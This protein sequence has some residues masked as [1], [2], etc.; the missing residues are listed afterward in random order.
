MS[1]IRIT[2]ANTDTSTLVLHP[3]RSFSSSSDGAVT[4]SI[5]VIAQSSPFFKEASKS[6]PFVDTPLDA[7][8]IDEFRKAAWLAATGS[9]TV[10]LAA[11]GNITGSGYA[12][13]KVA[14]LTLKIQDGAGN[15]Y[16]ASTSVDSGKTYSDSTARVIYTYNNSSDEELAFSIYNSIYQ[17]YVFGTNS[18]LP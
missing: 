13:A 18:V 11:S 1:F 3:S 14:D 12:A 15:T 16:F 17:A 9:S 6:G 5:R 4:G 10:S 7:S 2:K 8:S